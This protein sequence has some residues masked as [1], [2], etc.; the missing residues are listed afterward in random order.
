MLTKV[1][2]P[3][4]SLAALHEQSQ[5]APGPGK[6]VSRNDR[7][8]RRQGRGGAGQYGHSQR[9]RSPSY[10]RQEVEGVDAAGYA[11]NGRWVGIHRGEVQ[12]RL[13]LQL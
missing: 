7:A 5:H 12:A 3:S 9:L 6:P 8:G 11:R 13:T 10:G 2:S 4:T 1:V